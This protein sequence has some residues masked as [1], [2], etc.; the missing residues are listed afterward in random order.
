MKLNIIC[1]DLTMYNQQKLEEIA[2]T[3]GL[4]KDALIGNKSKGFKKIWIDKETKNLVC[5]TSK[6]TGD[7][8]VFVDDFESKLLQIKPVQ[9]PKKVKIMSVDSILDKIN[10][11][12]IESLTENEK[13]FLN[14]SSYD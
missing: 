10:K 14:E 9:L 11:W 2:L 5:F 7:E 3:Y 4:L 13:Q 12:G 1:I 8:I 6:M